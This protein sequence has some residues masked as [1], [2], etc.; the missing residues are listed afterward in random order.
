MDL[1]EGLGK[2]GLPVIRLTAIELRLEHLEEGQRT[3]KDEV[4][5][6]FTEVDKRIDDF[7]VDVDKCFDTVDRRF[8]K[9]ELRI[10]GTTNHLTRMLG[11]YTAIITLAVVLS[12]LFIP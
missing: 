8:D 3:F 5:R 12:Q 6:R 1:L 4:N 7:K 10:E 2:E 9:L 11:L